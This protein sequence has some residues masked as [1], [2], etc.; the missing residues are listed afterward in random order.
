[1]SNSNLT[2]FLELSEAE[3]FKE[4]QKAEIRFGSVKFFPDALGFDAETQGFVALHRKHIDMALHQELPVCLILKKLGFG[5]LLLNEADTKPS[6]DAKIGERFFEI[7]RISKARNV[8][9]A[10]VKQFRLAYKKSENLLLHIDQSA[11]PETVRNGVYTATKQVS[12]IKLVWVVFEERLF[13]FSRAEILK[14]KHQ[15]K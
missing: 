1:M 5:V 2:L 14:G 6:A 4:N 11:H 10:I 3:Y 13:H 12:K 7:K 15:Y 8:K 9:E